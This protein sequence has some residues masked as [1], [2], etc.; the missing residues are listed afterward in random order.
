VIVGRRHYKPHG[1]CQGP[2]TEVAEPG[3]GADPVPRR[4]PA[5]GIVSSAPLSPPIPNPNLPGPGP[6]S[7]VRHY[8][9]VRN[10]LFRSL[11]PFNHRPTT[12]VSSLP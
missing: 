4:S 10:S 2:V 7:D 1:C 5:R 3:D 9:R 12:S 11:D 6:P 8:A